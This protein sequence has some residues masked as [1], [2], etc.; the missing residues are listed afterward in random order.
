MRGWEQGG[1]LSTRTSS[2]VTLGGAAGSMLRYLAVLGAARLWPQALL[3]WGTLLVNLGG[4]LAIGLLYVLLVE[5]H[6]VPAEWRAL[7]LTG[8]VGGFTTF[9]AFALES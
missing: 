4:S 8:V 5:G 7:L 6:G 9:S 1:R 3:P 2:L